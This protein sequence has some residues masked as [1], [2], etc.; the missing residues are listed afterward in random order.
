MD[1]LTDIPQ[2]HNQTDIFISQGSTH[3]INQMRSYQFRSQ[4]GIYILVHINNSD[5]IIDHALSKEG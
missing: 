2:V 1:I 5:S 4:F 3:D